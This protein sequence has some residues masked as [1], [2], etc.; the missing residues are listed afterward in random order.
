MPPD[1]KINLHPVNFIILSGLLQ[2]FI[3]GTILLFYRKGK[4]SS[5]F[6]IGLFILLCSLHFAWS[7]VIDTNLGDIIKPLF[8]FPYSY[9]LALGPLIF[10]YTRSLARHEFRIGSSAL[11]HFLPVIFEILIQFYFIKEVLPKTEFIMTYRG[12]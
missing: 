5:N 7:L 3:L 10:L 12:L 11:T 6:L 2:C 8:W 4:R 9:L 1:I